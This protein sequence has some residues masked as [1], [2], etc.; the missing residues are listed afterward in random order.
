MWYKEVRLWQQK[1]E[2]WWEDEPGL[3]ALYPQCDHGRRP[4]DA[5]SH[6][7]DVIESRMADVPERGTFLMLLGIFGRLGHPELD[8]RQI[9]GVEKMKEPKFYQEIMQEG[10]LARLRKNILRALRVRMKAEPPAD[11]ASAVEAIDDV[12]RLEGPFD[13]S[14][15]CE[16]FSAFREALAVQEEAP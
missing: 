12:G 7:A 3:M 6:A 11:L 15:T 10:E 9:I 8:A 1:P 16:N 5:I 4:R 2:A 13:V 14:A